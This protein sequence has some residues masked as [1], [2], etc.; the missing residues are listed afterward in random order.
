M[1][2]A[3]FLIALG[4]L[5]GCL[6][7]EFRPDTA[8]PRPAQTAA[9][10]AFSKQVLNSAQAMSF[11]QNREYCGYIG[12]DSQGGFIA[13]PAKRGRKSSCFANVPAGFRVLASYHTHGAYSADHDTEVPS[14]SDLQADTYEGIDGYVGT[15]GG[16]VWYNDSERGTAELLCGLKCIESDPNFR[17][18]DTLPVGTVFDLADLEARE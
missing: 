1:K 2:K 8:E 18:Y 12:L 7:G 5:G 4:V 13:T 9:E 17:R 6:A 16:R 11:A 15:P 3:P 10:I 14:D